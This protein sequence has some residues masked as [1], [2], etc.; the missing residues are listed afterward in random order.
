MNL[1]G[2]QVLAHKISPSLLT[3]DLEG[4]LGIKIVN[5]NGLV[6]FHPVVITQSDTNG[7]WVT[8]LP[9]SA[10]VIVVGQGYVVPGQLV[11]AVYPSAETTVAAEN[12]H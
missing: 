3:L 11:E 10:T 6:E 9:E 4:N 8:G 2:T 7:V 5:D 12:L 1:P